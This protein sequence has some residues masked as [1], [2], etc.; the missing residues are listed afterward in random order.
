M[1]RLVKSALYSPAE[2]AIHD[3]RERISQ[4][5]SPCDIRE[6]VDEWEHA[7]ERIKK[8]DPFGMR[9]YELLRKV[10]GLK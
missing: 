6:Q 7:A 2:F 1:G 3:L 9:S 4:E 8:F 5:N 10:E